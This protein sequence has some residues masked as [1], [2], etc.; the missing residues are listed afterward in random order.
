[1]GLFLRVRG[2]GIFVSSWMR[3]IGMTLTFLHAWPI[4]LTSGSLNSWNPPTNEFETEKQKYGASSPSRPP[5]QTTNTKPPAKKK[6]TSNGEAVNGTADSKT[7]AIGSKTYNPK[8]P[9]QV[10]LTRANRQQRICIWALMRGKVVLGIQRAMR[11]SRGFIRIPRLVTSRLRR[12]GRNGWGFR[13]IGDREV[14]GGCR[15]WG[16]TL[17]AIG[18]HPNLMGAHVKIQEPEAD[19]ELPRLLRSPTTL[20][21]SHE[22]QIDSYSSP[23]P[24]LRENVRLYS[25]EQTLSSS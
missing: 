3:R 13:G 23:G 14:A 22:M 6:C 25:K 15:I 18:G 19:T 10:T 1:M 9:F 8:P 20:G 12:G 21:T 17:V 2:Q 24:R 16:D 5:S 4:N 7:T 11:F